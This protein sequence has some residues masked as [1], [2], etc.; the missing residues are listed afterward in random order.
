MS[1][2]KCMHADLKKPLALGSA[3][4][5]GSASKVLV[6]HLLQ[7]VCRLDIQVTLCFHSVLSYTV[8]YF[9]I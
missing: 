2:D 1:C 8:M 5:S 9:S 6:C 4:K 3:G 7:Q